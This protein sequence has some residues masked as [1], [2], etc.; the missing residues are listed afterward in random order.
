MKNIGICLLLFNLACL[1]VIDT[2]WYAEIYPYL[3]ALDTPFYC[4]GAI[5][6]F[7]ACSNK[8]KGM[9]LLQKHSFIACFFSLCLKWSDTII[10]LD[11]ETY[12]FWNLIII[13]IPFVLKIERNINW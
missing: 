12:M 6:F 7:K 9:T 11:Y 1:S 3:D 10:N 13:A 8:F 2:D 4:F 5:V